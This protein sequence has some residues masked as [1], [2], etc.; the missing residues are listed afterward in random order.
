MTLTGRAL[1]LILRVRWTLRRRAAT[2]LRACEVD[3]FERRAADVEPRDARRG[4]DNRAPASCA[5]L[6]PSR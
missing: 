1:A 4:A 3:V 2:M 6:M 5:P